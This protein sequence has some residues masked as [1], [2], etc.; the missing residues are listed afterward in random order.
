MESRVADVQR[1]Y[2]VMK[3]VAGWRGNLI[4][5][6]NAVYGLCWKE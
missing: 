6:W 1:L 5:G 3:N 4:I 2:I